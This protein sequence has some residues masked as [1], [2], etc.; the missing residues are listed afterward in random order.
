[1]S[2]LALSNGYLANIA[3]ICAPKIVRE[4]EREMASS[5]MAAFLGIGLAGGSMISFLLVELI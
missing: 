2:A 1:M 4:H 5:I 3:M